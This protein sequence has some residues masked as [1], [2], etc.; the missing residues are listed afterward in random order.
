[1]VTEGE[2]GQRQ[3]KRDSL[4]LSAAVTIEGV[5]PFSTRI[6]N[7]SAGGMMID[8]VRDVPTGTPLIADIRGI[9][10]V[11]GRIAWTS[12][13]RAGVAFNEE[14]DPQLAR[15]GTPSKHELPAFL[16]APT[17]RRPGLAIR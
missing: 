13:G 3:E 9:G 7:L 6:R 4:F 17:G 16:K 14:V 5:K 15:A 8:I 10:E 2:Q 12:P 11:A 1:M